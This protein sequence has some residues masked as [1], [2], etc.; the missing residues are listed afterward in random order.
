MTVL[1]RLVQRNPLLAHG[2]RAHRTG[3]ALPGDVAAES[4]R[5]RRRPMDV[6]APRVHLGPEHRSAA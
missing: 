5:R 1:D 3:I 6:D 4:H 2:P